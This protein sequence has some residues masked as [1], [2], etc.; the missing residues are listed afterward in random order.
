MAT[1]CECVSR[2]SPVCRST[3]LHHIWPLGM[4]GPDEPDNIE[5]LCPNQHAMTHMLIRLWGY[6]YNGEPPWWLRRH[7]SYLAR[8]LSELGWT[9]WHEAG[10]PVNQYN[11]LYQGE[12]AAVKK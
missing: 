9:R 3:H 11:W 2:H 12:K 1:R 4:G 5:V 7:F 10:R 6:R 8:Q